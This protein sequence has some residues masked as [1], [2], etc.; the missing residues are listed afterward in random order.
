M[1]YTEL[2]VKIYNF[3]FGFDK[4]NYVLY[5]FVIRERIKF[6]MYMKYVQNIHDYYSCIFWVIPV[7][8]SQICT[9]STGYPEIYEF[10]QPP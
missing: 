10:L 6:F 1:S 7:A 5:E 9:V 3:F 8:N 4:E 2:E